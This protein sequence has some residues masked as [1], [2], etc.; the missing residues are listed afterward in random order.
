M[1]VAGIPEE[2]I[3]NIK[4]PKRV[5]DVILGI[6]GIVTGKVELFEKELIDRQNPD[7]VR[8][9]LNSLHSLKTAYRT[10][11][12]MSQQSVTLSVNSSN[13]IKTKQLDTDV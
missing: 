1:D 2:R 4:D 10:Q 7:Q 9:V 3:M 5:V 12:Q 8:E 11:T 13:Q 6:L